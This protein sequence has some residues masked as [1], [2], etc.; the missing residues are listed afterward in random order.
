VDARFHGHDRMKKVILFLLIVV[1]GIFLVRNHI[2]RFT[3]QKFLTHITECDVSVDKAEVAPSLLRYH[4]KGVTL[5]DLPEFGGGVLAEI[6]EI[7]VQLS[8]WKYLIRGQIWI[9]KIFINFK[10]INIVRTVSGELNVERF[11]AADLTPAQKEKR[12]LFHIE[13]FIADIGTVTFKDGDSKKISVNLNIDGQVFKDFD[14]TDTIAQIVLTEI[15]YSKMLGEA[16]PIVVYLKPASKQLLQTIYIPEYSQI[17]AKQI[18]TSAQFEAAKKSLIDSAKF[19]GSAIKKGADSFFKSVNNMLSS[20]NSES[21]E[22]KVMSD[23]QLKKELG[24]K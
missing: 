11:K 16:M 21:Y 13:E 1:I 9:S 23:E 14:D 15:F 3:F 5:H 2:S 7:A 8:I 24:I 22:Q 19:T 10:E 17:T 20:F 6:P 12:A 4:F 18:A